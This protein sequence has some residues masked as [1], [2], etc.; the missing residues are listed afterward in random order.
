MLYS[1]HHA[2]LDL[3]LF[4]LEC[5][6]KCGS[7]SYGELFLFIPPREAPLLLCSPAVGLGFNRNSLESML[8]YKAH[9]VASCSTG[10][11]RQM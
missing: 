8:S 1:T 9:A 6:L 10:Y 2:G 11:W 4:Q 5:T 3:S 7:V